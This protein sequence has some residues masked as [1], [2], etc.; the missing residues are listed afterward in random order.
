MAYTP[1]KKK[2]EISQQL[3]EVMTAMVQQWET[4]EGT[5][6]RS[7]KDKTKDLP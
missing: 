7:D 3:I 5:M 6:R 2:N 1:R 4:L